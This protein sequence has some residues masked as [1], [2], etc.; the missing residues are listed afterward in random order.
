MAWVGGVGGSSGSPALAAGGGMADAFRVR[1]RIGALVET[2]PERSRAAQ[3][4]GQPVPTPASGCYGHR[5]GFFRARNP[6]PS[7][8]E[9]PKAK[10]QRP[11][12]LSFT[13]AAAFVA[14]CQSAAD[15]RRRSASS[16]CASV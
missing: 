2:N 16:S 3:G 14:A 12:N 9:L 10:T 13:T 6:P 7:V 8:P 1:E 4:T 15:R 5:R 11:T